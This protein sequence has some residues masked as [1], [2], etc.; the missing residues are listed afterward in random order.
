M[1]IDVRILKKMAENQ[2]VKQKHFF[3]K[4]YLQHTLA[5]T[6]LLQGSVGVNSLKTD[7]K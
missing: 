5:V 7:Y 1:C 3:T 4:L 2:D 6:I